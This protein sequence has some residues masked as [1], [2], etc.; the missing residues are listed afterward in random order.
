MQVK[1]E[2]CK[3]Q[4]S[5]CCTLSEL[6]GI[7]LFASEFSSRVIKI[8]TENETF[9]KRVIYDFWRVFSMEISFEKHAKSN[10]LICKIEDEKSIKIIFSELGYDFKEHVSYRLNRNIIEDDCCKI[11]FL[12]GVFLSSGIVIDPKKE[13][14]L[15]IVSTH[16]SLSREIIALM[17]DMER[18][19]KITE[20]K[21]NSVIYFKDSNQIEDFLTMLGAS[22]SAM[23]IMEAKVEK[24]LRNRVN[25]K[26][27]CETA[28]LSKT[29]EASANQCKVIKRVID[30]NGI[31]SFP[32]NLIETVKLRLENPIA[33]LAELANLSNPPCSKSGLSHRMRKIM[34]IAK[35]LGDDTHE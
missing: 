30:K 4:E 20:R 15:E 32:D 29:I 10:K 33:S 16:K 12:R 17:L 13:Y 22:N 35:A 5:M 1:K 25:R 8:V 14:H 7:C 28:N 2:M 24:D 27:N 19:P 3:T 23:D 6:Y 18:S 11:S 21:G 31:E 34:T 9:A 26:V